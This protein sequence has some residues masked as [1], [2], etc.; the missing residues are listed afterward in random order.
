MAASHLCLVDELQLYLDH[1]PEMS[2]QAQASASRIVARLFADGV[3]ASSD[4][5]N[6][7]RKTE[8]AG[9]AQDVEAAIG[10]LN[11]GG[12]TPADGWREAAHDLRGRLGVVKIAADLLSREQLP[13]EQREQSLR[14]LSNSVDWMSAFLNDLMQLARLE[15][16]HE[17]RHIK[18]LD[19]APLLK[20]LCN[21]LRPIANERR[22]FLT[23]EGPPALQVDGDEVKILRIAQNLIQNALLYTQAGGV[24]VMWA[25]DQ[26]L[27]TD[28]WE[29]CVQD[30]G[31]GLKHAEI[32]PIASAL[33]AATD[34]KHETVELAGQV[35]DIAPAT[36]LKSQSTEEPP[37][38]TTGEGVGLAI[39]KR[40]C[41]LLEATIELQTG[42][43]K[44]TTFRVEFP[45]R[46]D[47]RGPQASS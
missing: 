44:G 41:G 34:L 46:Y 18:R 25:L 38:V 3:C 42:P 4:R 20:E 35:P 21:A 23:V 31:P 1:H 17:P 27:D 13:E 28:R 43:G 5:Y 33:K 36:T 8:A 32:T 6:E 10:R 45:L 19:V 7:L 37:H 9:R 15:A 26:T 40:L 30:T 29:L 39:V 16:G 22:L 11:D 24:K 14:V 2:R 12:R 47:K